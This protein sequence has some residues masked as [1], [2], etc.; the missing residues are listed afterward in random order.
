MPPPSAK[1]DA[2]DLVLDA[3][4]APSL[5]R[6][7]H[8]F[9]SRCGARC[10]GPSPSRFA[11]PFPSRCGARYAA[12]SLSRFAHPFPSRCGALALVRYTHPYLKW[13]HELSVSLAVWPAQTG[14]SPQTRQISTEVRTECHI[15]G[16]TGCR[17]KRLVNRAT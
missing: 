2:A 10:A 8:P 14:P 6:F 12:P 11:H 15:A 4:A 1:K 17:W 3:A 5:S 16:N 13:T 7:A 9:P